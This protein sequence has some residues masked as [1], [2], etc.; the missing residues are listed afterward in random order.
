[1]KFLKSLFFIVILGA[2]G[3]AAYFYLPILRQDSSNSNTNINMPIG[4]NLA[5]VEGIAEYRDPAGSWKEAKADLNL[6]QGSS[7]KITG[8]GRAIINLDDGSALRIGADSSMTL[9]KLDPN[10]IIVVNNRGELYLR[11][12]KSSRIF[13]VKSDGITYESMGTAYKTINKDKT[14]GVEVYE[15]KVKIIG[16]EDAE[17]IVDQGKK[18]Y[19]ANETDQSSVKVIKELKLEEIK[20]DE[21][22][23]WNKT[24]DESQT[25]FKDEMG[26]LS[27]LTPPELSITSPENGAKTKESSIL[28]EGKTDAEAKILINNAEVKNESGVFSYKANLNAGE[29]KIKISVV[30]TAGNK[31]EKE[32]TI[33]KVVMEPAVT[34]NTSIKLSAVVTTGGIKFS[35]TVGGINVDQGFKLIKSLEINPV[36]PGNDYQ[37]LTES[38]TRSYTWKISDGK[39]YYFRVCQYLGGKCGVYSNNV[40]I[41]A[42]LAETNNTSG[43][44][45]SINLSAISG[46]TV[47]WTLNGYSSQGFKVVWSETSGPTYPTR[48]ADQ[49]NYYSDPGQRTST[50]QAFNG[51]GLYY[52][53]VCEYLGGSCGVYS[54]QIQINL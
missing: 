14:Q 43:V 40:K 17:V 16:A 23:M 27:D 54:N 31:T 35:W 15:S 25:E 11:I 32:L 41:K 48:S 1:M 47:S 24:Q 37:Y 19:L 6:L 38:G 34:N 5:Y 33:T 18:Y 13:E 8:P 7:L 49:Y 20:K 50:L 29:N 30:D 10:N 46:A 45:K 4:A 3:A 44:V 26:I 9:E 51:S 21:F 22:V 36:Y 42:P 28:I 39:T 52:V 2:I 12:A 53:R